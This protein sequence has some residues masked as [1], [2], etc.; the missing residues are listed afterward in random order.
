LKG[1]AEIRT[2]I[3]RNARAI[4]LRPSLARGSARTKVRVT[5]GL[6]C[7]IEE[8]RFRLVADMHEKHGGEDLGPT[9]GVYGRAAL[10]SCLA[11]G[12]MMFASMRGVEIDALE[13]EI[14]ADYDARPELGMTDEQ[15][16][17]ERVRY[18]VSVESPA[19]EEEVMRVL[20]ETDAHS[21]YLA[22]FSKPQVMERAVRFRSRGATASPPDATSP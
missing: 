17:Y 4:G 2:A 14:E 12:Y 11:I 9:P 15:P 22:V 6:T 8:G 16:G 20:D 13:V 10:G 19:S 18:T 3:E 7:E 1:Q 21:P 5:S